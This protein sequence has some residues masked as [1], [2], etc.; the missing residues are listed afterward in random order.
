MARFLSSATPRQREL[1]GFPP[2]GDG[3]WTDKFLAA[4]AKRYPG[5]DIVPYVAARTNPGNG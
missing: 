2:P 5:F 3:L 1:L 4:I